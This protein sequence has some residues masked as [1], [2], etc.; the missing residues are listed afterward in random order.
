ML[1]II[2]CT[3]SIRQLLL[4]VSILV[5]SFSHWVRHYS[6][7]LPINV[8]ITFVHC[9]VSS[10]F[11]CSFGS[12]E[13][14]GSPCDFQGTCHPSHWP[15]LWLKPAKLMDFDQLQWIHLQKASGRFSAPMK[16]GHLKVI[17]FVVFVLFRNT[18]QERWK[19]CPW[20]AMLVQNRIYIRIYKRVSEN[21][22]TP[23]S[24]ILIGFSIINHPIWGTPIFGITHNLA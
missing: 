4:Y 7:N 13:K 18:I 22:G 15:K 21:S 24:S 17:H 19:R 1:S 12:L 3:A 2:S 10:C 9:I 6:K 16:T 8:S 11:I 23:K 20:F 14:F 5:Y